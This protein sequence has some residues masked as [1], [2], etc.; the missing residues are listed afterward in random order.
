[1]SLASR[2]YVLVCSWV[3][4][5]VLICSVGKV[6]DLFLPVLFMMR[7]TVVGCKRSSP[8]TS[9]AHVTQYGNCQSGAALNEN[10]LFCQRY[11]L[12]TDMHY[13]I[14]EHPVFVNSI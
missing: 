7:C 11:M 3:I 2:G 8:F 1:M 12:A 13:L 6:A 5:K 4:C 10:M 14:A 9:Y